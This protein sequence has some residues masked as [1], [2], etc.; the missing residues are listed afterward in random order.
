MPR[1]KVVKESNFT[2]SNQFDP[3]RHAI[4]VDKDLQHIFEY[5]GSLPQ[6]AATGTDAPTTTPIKIGDFFIDTTNK[7]VY[8]S[9]GTS[10]SADWEVL[11]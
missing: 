7:K 11:N 8:A 2:V 10:T 4:M 3:K 6:Y 1:Q 9:C 5:S